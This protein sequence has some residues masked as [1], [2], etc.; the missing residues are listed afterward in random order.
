MKKLARY[1]SIILDEFG[2]PSRRMDGALTCIRQPWNQHWGCG[3]YRPY[4]M[5]A[6]NDGRLP[7]GNNLAERGIKLLVIGRKNFL[8]SGTPRGAEAAAGMRSI[9]V[10]AKANGLN[11][12]K[13]V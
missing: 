4:A 12:R 10:A 6:L 2:G 3:Q 13:Y 5:G 7:L 9:V 1:D 8:F 11:P